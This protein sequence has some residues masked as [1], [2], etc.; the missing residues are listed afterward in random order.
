MDKKCIVS[1]DCSVTIEHKQKFTVLSQ[2]LRAVVSVG[3]WCWGRKRSDIFGFLFIA[4]K[5]THH[6][7][8]CEP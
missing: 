2:T 3:V 8:F 7:L 6:L 1:F 4:F 5:C